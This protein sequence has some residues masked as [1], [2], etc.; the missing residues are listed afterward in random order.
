[1]I[2][3]QGK[4]RKIIVCLR[5]PTCV[6][7]IGQNQVSVSPRPITG[8]VE[9]SRLFLRYA[10]W[11]FVL[12]TMTDLKRFVFSFNPQI[13]FTIFHHNRSSSTKIT[14]ISRYFVFAAQSF[15]IFIILTTRRLFFVTT[16]YIKFNIVLS[17]EKYVNCTFTYKDNQ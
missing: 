4:T 13:Y 10:Y 2:S 16:P 9:H 15:I 12:K 17:Y 7:P 8:R 11:P 1:M 5:M 3:N 14:L 6:G